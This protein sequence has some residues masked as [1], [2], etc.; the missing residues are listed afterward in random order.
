MSGHMDI[1]AKLGINVFKA[2]SHPHIKI[3]QGMERDHRLRNAIRLCPARLYTENVDGTVS[4]EIDGCLE[5]GTCR[6]AC[7]EI[8]EWDYPEGGTGIQFRYG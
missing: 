7:G 8:L 3:K 2:L 5:C 4:I 6:I 1:K